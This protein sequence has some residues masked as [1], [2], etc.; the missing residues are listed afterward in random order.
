MI[1]LTGNELLSPLEAKRQ[2]A[3]DLSNISRDGE[4]YDLLQPCFQGL[5][6]PLQACEPNKTKKSVK[7]D[8]AKKRLNKLKAA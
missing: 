4:P 5:E 8:R 1:T 6:P 3:R 2:H 7:F